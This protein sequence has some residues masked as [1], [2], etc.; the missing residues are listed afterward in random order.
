MTSRVR[1][2][3]LIVGAGSSGAALAAGLVRRGRRVLLLEAGRNYVASDLPEVWRSPNPFNAI[4]DQEL[5]G[6]LWDDLAASRTD[7]QPPQLYWRGKG[8]GGSSV[9]NGQ[10]AIRPP[11]EDFDEWA[12]DGCAGWSAADVMPAFKALESDLDFGRDDYHG[13]TG[14]IPVFRTPV[15]RWGAVDEAL[16]E[17][18]LASGLPWAPDVNAPGATGVSPYPINSIDQRRV[19][20]NDA[21]LEPI[22]DNPLLTIRGDSLVDQ[23][24][25][26]GRRAVGVRL[27]D[28]TSFHAD[29][30]V[31]SA[32][33][34]ASPAILLRSGI[35]PARDLES[36]GI[37]VRADLPVGLGLQ[38][39]PL[40]LIGVPLTEAASAGPEDRHT[41]CCVRFSSGLGPDENDMMLVSLNQNA[42]AMASVDLR[43]G[44]GALG[45]F[46]NRPYSRGVLRLASADPLVQPEVR[47]RMLSDERDLE[48]LVD[49]V[50]RL[51]TI[52]DHGAFSKIAA[53]DI[54]SAN[55]ELSKALTG[56][57]SGMR[58]YLLESVT[59]TQHPTSTCRMGASDA[60]DTVV[61]SDCRVV[62][63]EGLRVVDA[64][65]FPFVP[66]ANTHLTCVMAGEHMAR[67]M[68]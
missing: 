2:D 5:G 63:V 23:V 38:D 61:D 30:V 8:V 6:Y 40:A 1:Y 65:I 37:P 16:R 52:I 59:D 62:G 3:A 18:A 39:H 11:V 14:P 43:S 13:D 64:S 25:F 53:A 57:P 60:A 48:R 66:R 29:E 54:R 17:A 19:S 26:E 22:R 15:E 51:M 24:L 44:A 50:E 46:V 31:L 4:L 32:G 21:Y 47:L 33:A 7:A 67:R 45:V 34:I 10:I 20:S 56:P 49:G 55:P 68:S 9:I 41:N 28:G 58:R 27:A 42:L 36:L 12:A 35:G